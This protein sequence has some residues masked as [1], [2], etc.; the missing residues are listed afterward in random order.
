VSVAAIAAS[1]ALSLF[2]K[3]LEIA[4]HRSE[5]HGDAARFEQWIAA[6]RELS[7]KL[8]RCAEEDAAA[9]QEYMARRKSPEEAAALRKAIEVP[10]EAARA[11]AAG[12]R[13]C[14]EAAASV[15]ASIAP[16]LG[17]AGL[18]L[19]A[20]VRGITLSIESNVQHLADE[21]FADEVRREVRELVV[22]AGSRV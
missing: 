9:Y 18:L 12:V 3:V 13:I 21:K 1:L 4:R 2:E 11:A 6:A 14:A 17:T 8:A 16:D 7:E 10:L 19:A 15:P 22:A 20:A 5:F